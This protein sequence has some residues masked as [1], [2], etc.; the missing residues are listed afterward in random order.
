M[1]TSHTGIRWLLRVSSLP[2]IDQS[3]TPVSTSFLDPEFEGPV[4]RKGCGRRVRWTERRSRRGL[5]SGGG[6][7]AGE[8]YDEGGDLDRR[9]P[10]TPRCRGRD[11]RIVETPVKPPLL[12]DPT[13][14]VDPGVPVV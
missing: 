2:R 12:P 9:D 10:V 8:P 11:Q 4:V 7:P 5:V 13:Y 1:T 6:G 14:S 3:L